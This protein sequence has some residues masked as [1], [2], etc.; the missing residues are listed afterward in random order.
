MDGPPKLA[1]VVPA[2]LVDRRPLL[3]I[4]TPT[5]ERPDLLRRSLGSV[6]A[7][8]DPRASRVEL[9]VADN[10]VTDEP[11]HVARSLLESWPGPT[12]YVRNRPPVG[13]VGNHNR[14]ID[15]ATGRNIAFLHDD[16]MLVPDGLSGVLDVIES[17]SAAAVHLFGVNVVR[18][19]GSIRRRQRPHRDE[20]LDPRR[21]LERLLVD[22]SFVRLPGIVAR[23]DAYQEAGPFDPEVGNATD[24]DM[25]T[26]LFARHGLHTVPR[27]LAAYTVHDEALTTTM[28]TPA[29]IAVLMKIFER[30]ARLGPLTQREV[31]RGQ[32]RWFHKFVLA[33][34][35]RSLEVGDRARAA[36]IMQLFQQP[37]VRRLGPSARWLPVRAAFTIATL[38]ARPKEPTDHSA[39]GDP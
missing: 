15:L 29:T 23:A 10:S 37:A 26:R 18:M 14:C 39:P 1:D 28:F 33:G 36:E 8:I 30:A 2:D 25:W 11:E 19:D 21:A 34:A 12:Q 6:V 32:T 31:R 20:Q 9:L 4:C 7:Q 24:F 5:H 3:T 16:D 27:T 38:G 17:P 35:F 13:M 22:S